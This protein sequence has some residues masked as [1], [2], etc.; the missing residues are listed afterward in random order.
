M[1]PG[2][3]VRALSA[4]W[5]DHGLTGALLG[6][7]NPVLHGHLPGRLLPLSAPGVTAHSLGSSYS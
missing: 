6:L 7:G 4:A 1:Q 2:P 3:M 5:G